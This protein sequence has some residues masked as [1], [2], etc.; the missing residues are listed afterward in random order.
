M[1]LKKQEQI[2]RDCIKKKNPSN[3]IRIRKEE[4]QKAAKIKRKE[5]FDQKRKENDDDHDDDD[6][7]EIYV[8]QDLPKVQISNVLGNELLISQLNSNDVKINSVGLHSLKSDTLGKLSNKRLI[9]RL[10]F[11][12]LSKH[13]LE[14]SIIDCLHYL[15]TMKPI[16]VF[17][18]GKDIFQFLLISPKTRHII[19]TKIY[20]IFCELVKNPEI[21]EIFAAS[22]PLLIQ[23][24]VV[25]LKQ[26]LNQ[27][28]LELL[29]VLLRE[30]CYQKTRD[31]QLMNVILEIFQSTENPNDQIV[32]SILEQIIDEE[33]VVRCLD[34]KI[35]TK[36][37][38]FLLK[39]NDIHMNRQALNVF[40]KIFAM[41]NEIVGKFFANS[42]FI[43][44]WLVFFIK[45]NEKNINQSI[46]RDFILMVSN[47]CANSN[48]Q[49]RDQIHHSKLILYI[50]SFYPKSDI[51]TKNEMF[52]LVPNFIEGGATPTQMNELLQQIS[53]CLPM[54]S[55]DII[56]FNDK[57]I[58]L[59]VLRCFEIIF[60][61]LKSSDSKQSSE[62]YKKLLSSH[63]QLIMQV[64]SQTTDEDIK[65]VTKRIIQTNPI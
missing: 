19:K 42:D 45:Q 55:Q 57:E 11:F 37:S 28:S 10:F 3:L 18:M 60:V 33:N 12:L 38:G 15:S 41:E 23:I 43:S 34:P 44:K 64:C 5:I 27:P 59:R 26:H 51:L 49:I 9:A 50:L 65:Q 30:K 7:K 40:S 31:D 6:Q 20:A 54:I 32:M 61:L 14:E 56:K 2:K 63:M 53:T 47:L 52:Y 36:I 4:N 21:S 48:P 35:V 17:V 8:L 16:P 39:S 13:P 22:F 58:I 1:D 62:L 46:F 29:D 24:L 25:H